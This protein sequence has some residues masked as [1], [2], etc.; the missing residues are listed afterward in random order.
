MCIAM[1]TFV[2]FFCYVMTFCLLCCVYMVPLKHSVLIKINTE[3]QNAKKTCTTSQKCHTVLWWHTHTELVMKIRWI[4][5]FMCRKCCHFSQA[6]LFFFYFLFITHRAI[7]K[8]ICC[9]QCWILSCLCCCTIVCPW[10][11]HRIE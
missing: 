3:Q 4:I 2:Y 8:Q 1:L 10:Q 7:S 6:S 5:F 9:K 11:N